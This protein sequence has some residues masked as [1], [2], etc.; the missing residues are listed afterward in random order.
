MDSGSLNQLVE[1]L[2][3]TGNLDNHLQYIDQVGLQLKDLRINSFKEILLLNP[4]SI[5][6]PGNYSHDPLLAFIY[7]TAHWESCGTIQASGARSRSGPPA[8]LFPPCTESPIT[9]IMVFGDFNTRCSRM[10]PFKIPPHYQW[11]SNDYSIH[12]DQES[13]VYVFSLILNSIY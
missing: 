1:I 10:A 13:L 3:P 7:G 9:A 2:G 11:P 4:D 12:C 5:H 8:F 6:H